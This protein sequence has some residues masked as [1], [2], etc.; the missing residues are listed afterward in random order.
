MKRKISVL[1]IAALILH[2]IPVPVYAALS[3][4]NVTDE[5]MNPISSG[6]YGDL[7]YVFGDGVISG[8]G[9][10]LYWDTVMAWDGETGLLNSSTAHP[11]G[12]FEI[13]FEVPEAVNGSHY[14]WIRDTD[15][16]AHTF[17][18]VLFSV[19]AIM[20]GK[21]TLP[22]SRNIFGNCLIFISLYTNIEIKSA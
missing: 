2:M 7:V 15:T 9:V 16:P 13:W 10:N 8:L 4:T 11:S 22:L 5:G 21:I 12:A 1:V 14:L 18:P 19:N 3:I 6:V 20:T 17:G